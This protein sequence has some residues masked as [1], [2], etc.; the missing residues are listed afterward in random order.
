[1]LGPVVFVVGLLAAQSAQPL[2]DPWNQSASALSGLG[3]TSPWVMAGTLVLVGA[4]TVLT[5]LGLRPRVPATAWRL[6]AAGGAFLVVAG[7]SPQPVG[8]YSLVHM[9]A[10]ALAW[11]AYTLWPLGLAAS[12]RVDRGL[13]L[14]SAAASL[15]LSVLVVWFTAQ[16]VTD[17][18]WYGLSQRIVILAQAAWPVVVALTVTGQKP[19]SA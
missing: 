14:A 17:G 19:P 13:R 2:P 9:V 7:L 1:V 15:V 3:A 5:A 10:G 6:L 8:G 11:A 12:A 4:L 16:L 18:T